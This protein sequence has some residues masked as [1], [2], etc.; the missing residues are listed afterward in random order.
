MRK[1]TVAVWVKIEAERMVSSLHQAA[2][3][4]DKA[5][6][7]IILDFSSVRRIDPGAVRE[8]EQLIGTADDRAIKVG[9][10]GVNIHVYK[11]LKLM[12][13]APRFSFLT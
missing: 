1:A 9:L 11:V 7:E 2:E 13:L 10:R 12:K 4:L 3:K 6:D 8:I 5:K